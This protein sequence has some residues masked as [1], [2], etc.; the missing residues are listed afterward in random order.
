M[1]VPEINDRFVL[2]PQSPAYRAMVASGWWLRAGFVALSVEVIA[3]IML[4]TGDASPWITIAAAVLAGVF[5]RWSW[6]RARAAMDGETA[7]ANDSASAPAEPRAHGHGGRVETA[8][9]R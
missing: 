8:V 1:P 3:L 7:A 6:H 9:M 5:A 4:A 2:D